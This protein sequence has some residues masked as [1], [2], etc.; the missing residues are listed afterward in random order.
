MT[1]EFTNIR[2][3]EVD[4]ACVT[5]GTDFI[6]DANGDVW[7]NGDLGSYLYN[8]K[9]GMEIEAMVD[10]Q[11]RIVR[12]DH[13]LYTRDGSRFLFYGVVPID[14]KPGFSY[15]TIF[16]SQIRKIRGNIVF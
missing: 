15:A 4:M 12:I 2:I 13:V 6:P 8:L 11:I 14:G 7:V 9:D 10:H 5:G 16:V 1:K 3:S